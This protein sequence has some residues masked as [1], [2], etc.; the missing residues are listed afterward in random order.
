MSE[1]SPGSDAVSSPNTGWTV[2][3]GSTNNAELA[4]GVERAES[5][6]TGTT[7][8]DGTPDTSLGDCLRTT[9]T[10]TG[11]FA[12]ANWNVHFNCA[13]VSSGGS[14]DGRMICRLLRGTNA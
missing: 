13:S 6:F 4:A 14:Q 7:V 10:Y 3:T 12:S 1:T 8:P 9:N 5:T 2:G 11:S